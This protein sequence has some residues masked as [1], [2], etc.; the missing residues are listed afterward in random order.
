MQKAVKC[1]VYSRVCGYYTPTNVWNKGKQAEFAARQSV[2]ISQPWSAEQEQK[3][4]W[5]ALQL[6][7]PEGPPSM[8]V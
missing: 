4:I 5:L 3:K 6:G 7:G 8:V 1:D 2:D